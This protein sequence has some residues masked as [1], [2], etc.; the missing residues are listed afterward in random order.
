MTASSRFSRS[1][2]LALCGAVL[3]LLV[4]PASA[5]ALMST[6]DGGW[7]WLDPQPQGNNLEAVVALDAQHAVVGGD[8]GALL[9]TTDGGATWSFRDLRPRRLTHR[10]PRFVGADAG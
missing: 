1:F 3:S 7:Q 9:T 10:S 5:L 4:L 8:S 6:A 2:F